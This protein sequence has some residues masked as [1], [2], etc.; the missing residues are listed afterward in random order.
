MTTPPPVPPPPAGHSTPPSPPGT[1][2]RRA[3]AVPWLATALVLALALAGY[4][5]V[6]T[7]QWQRTA[8]EWEGEA[9]RYASEAAALDQQ[10]EGANAELTAARDQLA[11][12]TGRISELA[13]EKAQLGDENVASQQHLDYQARVSEAAAKVA[14]A[15]G[16]CVNAQEQLIGYLEDA[17]AYDPADLTRFQ[18]QVGDLCDKANDANDALQAELAS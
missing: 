8:Q 6:T 11:A 7:T 16:S 4:L 2:R 18:N 5:W 1:G 14:V 12:A 3:V 9:H 10:L 17:D 13:N 15:L